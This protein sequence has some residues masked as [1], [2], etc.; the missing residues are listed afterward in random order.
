[1]GTCEERSSEAENGG[2]G[3]GGGWFGT[4]RSV[5]HVNFPK[6]TGA[7]SARARSTAEALYLNIEDKAKN[8]ETKEA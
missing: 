7:R 2:L 1:M 3:G 6:Q 4:Q 5:L 8:I